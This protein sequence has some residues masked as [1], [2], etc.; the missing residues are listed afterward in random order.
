[1][2]RFLLFIPFMFLLHCTLPEP[3][4]VIPPLTAVIYPYE[5]AVISSNVE[6][7]IQASDNDKL[8]KVWYY[9][10]GVKIAEK[11]KAPFTFNMNISGLTK[12]VTHVIQSA[13]QDK[14]GNIGYSPLVNFMVAETQDITPPT[15]VI[16][17]PQGGQVVEGI[18]NVTAYAEDERSVQK[19]AFFIDGDSVGFKASYPYIFNWNTDTLSDSTAHTIFAKAFDSGNNTAISPTIQVTVYPRTGEAGDNI[20]PSALFL[21]PI[22]G[23]TITGTV[24]VSV[25]LQ[26]NVGVANAEFYVDGELE[27]SAANPA[28]PWVFDWDSSGKADSGSH[29]LYVK[30]YDAAGNVGTSGLLVV[31]IE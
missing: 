9:V 13:A 22:T 31:I 15:V 24:R 17:N 25:D 2:K 30:V 7:N 27:T 29:T 12:K 19:V 10:N 4:D 14:E 21:Y 26:D 28:V 6:V 11:A 3:S 18:V 16:V 5:G 1:M 20:A 8:S 23:T